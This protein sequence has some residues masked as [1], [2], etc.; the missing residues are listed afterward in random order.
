MN[1]PDRDDLLELRGELRRLIDRAWPVERVRRQL[2]SEAIFDA[3]GWS[4]LAGSGVSGVL[5]PED[6][7]GIDAGMTTA[8]V[9]AGELGRRLVPSPFLPVT[10]ATS[11]LIEGTATSLASSWIPRMV[12]GDVIGTVALTAPSGNPAV[13]PDLVAE[14]TE[15]GWTLNGLAGYVPYGAQAQFVV[16]A[17]GA[18]TQMLLGV[19]LPSDGVRVHTRLMHDRTQPLADL[20]FVNVEVPASAVIATLEEAERLRRLLLLR[21]AALLAADAAGAARAI[22]DESVAYAKQRRQFDRPIGSFQAV[23]HM[24][25]DM[26]VRTEGAAAAARGAA[27]T[28]DEGRTSGDR[29]VAL[30]AAYALD[31]FVSIAGDAIQVHGGMGYTW[32]HDCHM[33]LKRAQLDEVL[34]GDAAWLRAQA[35]EAIFAPA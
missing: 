5:A 23:K 30:A 8:E 1:I 28:L 33:F 6:L 10:L 24:L 4:E 7:G 21:A 27:A 31:A 32:E 29:R 11:A 9:F 16:V 15:A 12:D 34:F 22:L 2:D 20:V 19:E 14:R 26:H 25:A 18:P 13:R 35:A 17:V 3:E